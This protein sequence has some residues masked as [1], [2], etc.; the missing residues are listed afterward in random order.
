ME[1]QSKALNQFFVQLE[2]TDRE[3][4]GQVLEGCNR[5][6]TRIFEDMVRVFGFCCCEVFLVSA[7]ECLGH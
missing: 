5:T 1:E 7:E 6:L 4:I 3:R 2:Y